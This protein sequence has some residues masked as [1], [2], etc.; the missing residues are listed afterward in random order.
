MTPRV[1]V[2]ELLL[3]ADGAAAD[4][5]DLYVFH[6]RCE[7]INVI[8]PPERPAHRPL[9]AGL[10]ASKAPARRT[11]RRQPAAPPNLREMVRIA[12]AL[13]AETD[14]VRVDLYDLGDRVV[15]GELTNTPIA[16]KPFFDRAFDRMLG[17]LW[18]RGR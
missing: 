10:D 6:G 1:L 4:D 5:Y 17:E 7:H 3:A 11:G 9:P 15:F 14:F 12:E 2:E 16:G 8:P 13:G 18:A